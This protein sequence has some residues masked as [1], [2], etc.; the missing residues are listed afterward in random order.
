[1]S[2]DEIDK[3]RKNREDDE[4]IYKKVKEKSKKE[5]KSILKKS[6][7]KNKEVIKEEKSLKNDDESV[8]EEFVF[9]ETEE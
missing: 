4:P 5:N 6:N 9:G 2:K 1:M 8:T 3:I 7:Y